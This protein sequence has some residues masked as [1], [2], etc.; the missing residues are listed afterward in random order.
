MF[1]FRVHVNIHSNDPQYNAIFTTDF[2]Q[3][4]KTCLKSTVEST[5]KG[6]K[7]VQSKQ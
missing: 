7:Y 5:E 6:V 4:I 3:E 1:I 2:S